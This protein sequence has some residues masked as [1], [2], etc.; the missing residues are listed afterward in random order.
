MR[1]W[2]LVLSRANVLMMSENGDENDVFVCLLVDFLS[3]VL[4]ESAFL[5]WL[6]VG[7]RCVDRLVSLSSWLLVLLGSHDGRRIS[8]S[9][10]R[11]KDKA[12][13]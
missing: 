6:C 1:I 13:C 5:C 9:G 7:G 11:C 12:A 10:S 8:R 4:L 3:V 2:L